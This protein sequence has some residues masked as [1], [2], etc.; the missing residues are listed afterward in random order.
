MYQV[1]GCDYDEEV[2]VVAVCCRRLMMMTQW[3]A[4][5]W[6]QMKVEPWKIGSALV[7]LAPEVAAV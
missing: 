7:Y 3:M 4:D 6:V 2:E 5:C 1:P